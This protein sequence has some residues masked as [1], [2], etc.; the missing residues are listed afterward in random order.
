M[1]KPGELQIFPNPATGHCTI[2]I[3][4]ENQFE[5]YTLFI[6]NLMGVKMDEVVVP[7]GETQVELSLSGYAPGLYSVVTSCQGSVTGRG[8]FVVY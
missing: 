6:Y 2:A 1:E 3:P 8:K 4:K 7:S 5:T